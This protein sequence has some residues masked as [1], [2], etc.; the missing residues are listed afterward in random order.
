MP[1]N[2]FETRKGSVWERYSFAG[3]ELPDIRSGMETLALEGLRVYQDVTWQAGTCGRLCGK[4]V[5]PSAPS[6]WAALLHSWLAVL[7]WVRPE[8]RS[9]SCWSCPTALV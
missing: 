2:Q 4:W 6:R 9:P 1:S 7:P 5:R 3:Q 8:F